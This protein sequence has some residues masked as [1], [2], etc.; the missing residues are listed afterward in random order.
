M[1]RVLH[2]AESKAHHCVSSIFIYIIP[3]F[4]L[5]T[6]SQI[7]KTPDMSIRSILTNNHHMTYCLVSL[8][9][10]SEI[11]HKEPTVQLSSIMIV[12]PS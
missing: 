4:D 3:Q 10:N 11:D 5:V 6:L 8:F 7:P 1:M 9:P 2:A 12:S